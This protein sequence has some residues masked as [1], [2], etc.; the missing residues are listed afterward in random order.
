MSCTMNH[1]VIL[2][3]Y[4]WNIVNISV[5][6]KDPSNISSIYFAGR[7]KIIPTWLCRYRYVLFHNNIYRKKIH[8]NILYIQSRS[9]IKVVNCFVESLLIV[10][11]N[12]TPM[13]QRRLRI[14]CITSSWIRREPRTSAW[15]PTNWREIFSFRPVR[16]FELK[17]IVSIG[18]RE[19]LAVLPFNF[20][21]NEPATINFVVKQQNHY[22]YLQYSVYSR[23]VFRAAFV[24]VY[25]TSVFNFVEPI[26]D[27]LCCNFICI[28]SFVN[29]WVRKWRCSWLKMV[30]SKLVNKYITYYLR[31]LGRSLTFFVDRSRIFENQI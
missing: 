26:C 13:S 5:I 10:M 19:A 24:G 27:Y 14:R 28:F 18:G 17:S 16:K 8:Y 2:P 1:F 4:F 12:R 9:S 23:K 20:F 3:K 15:R 31:H 21:I 6:L 22:C 7:V 25:Y 30:S 11:K 29:L